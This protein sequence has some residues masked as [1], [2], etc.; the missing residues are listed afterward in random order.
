MERT[1]E[2][3]RKGRKGRKGQ[4]SVGFKMQVVKDYVNGNRSLR[5]LALHYGVSRSNIHEW[6]QQF[7]PELSNGS[8]PTTEVMTEAEQREL[9]A[10]K[11]QNE[12]LKKKLEYADMKATALEIMI[13]IAEKQ[14][15]IDIKK[16]PGTKQ[17]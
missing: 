6:V 12:E 2:R 3:G 13:D 14:L 10:L 7:Y 5:Q 15:G 9:E 4:H 17:Q 1:K 16:K 11:K 8:L